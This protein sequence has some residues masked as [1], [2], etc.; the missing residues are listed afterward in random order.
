MTATEN[1]YRQIIE[2]TAEGY[3]LLSA[4]SWRVIEVND[5]LCGL[6]GT[7]PSRLIGRDFLELAC[8]ESREELQLALE[9]QCVDGAQQRF[10][11][12]LCHS[13]GR[14]L[15]T[16]MTAGV[17]QD[18][19]GEKTQLFCMVCDISD[20]KK[21]EQELRLAAT[22]FE[23]TSEAIAVTDAHNHIIAVNP[24]F[25]WITGYSEEEVLGRDPS[26]L[27]SGRHSAAFYR[28]M[29]ET[30]QRLGR[31]QG[32]IWNRRKNGEVFPEWLSIVA[33]K[34]ERGNVAQH[35]AVFSDITRRKQDEKK[36]WH[37]ANFDALTGLPN[38]TLFLDRL[39]QAMHQAHRDKRQLALMFIDL[40]R[41]KYVN[42]T[43]GHAA[44][45]QLLRE[46]AQRIR[47][48]VTESDTVARLGGDEFTV[49]LG[50]YNSIIDVEK[51]AENI[52]NTLTQPFAVL[53]REAF[54]S[55]SIGITLYPDDATEMEQ[56][57]RNADSAMYRA[58]EAGR[59]NFRYFTSE[60]NDALRRRL[61]LE[62]DLR[63]AIEKGEIEVHFQPI[64]NNNGRVVGAEALARWNHHELGMIAPDEFI[65]LAEEIGVITSIEQWM[66][67]R[68][69][70]TASQWN[71]LGAGKLFV[72]V[73][74]STLQC[75]N[76][77]CYEFVREVLRTTDIEPSQLK[78]EI[79]ER[80][81]MEDTENVV[82][83]LSS[84]RTSGI[85]LAI[86]D[87]GT[88]FSSLSY[89]K[90]FPVDVLKI[91]RSFVRDLPED[92][93]DVGLVEAI[94]AMAKSLGLRLVAEGVETHEQL[95]FLHS[96]GVDMIQGYYYSP[97]LTPEEFRAFVV[98]NSGSTAPIE[99]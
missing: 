88:G 3:C 9:S 22:F 34:D 36:I 13:D 62:H 46:A 18:E 30:L 40:D 41:F 54:V 57:L 20:Q 32:E 10:E 17:L 21:R 73:N 64:L 44:G 33:I 4:G 49:V 59:N 25:C 42:E 56:L 45:D 16:R 82:G 15:H 38:R 72:A 37:Q 75:T 83:L 60:M 12:L 97:A 67:R 23:T 94:V 85:Q 77:H 80:V 26:L 50:N 93:D 90:R 78:L 31:W 19:Q 51:R 66:M 95:A 65:P 74:I 27:S 69:V 98:M 53:D 87:F 70:D 63:R 79:T 81:M 47:E 39:G 86:D 5:A 1:R 58:K 96:L 48:N 2:T 91:D 8:K 68:A 28:A 89:L 71:S 76:T 29:W 43:L 92:R 11:T 55:G 14:K 24:A 52:L 35:M 61:R 99:A 84:L 6:L 7:T